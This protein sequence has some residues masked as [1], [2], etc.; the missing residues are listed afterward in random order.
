M[1]LVFDFVYFLLV[2][3]TSVVSTSAIIC[4]ERLISEVICYVLNGTL[5][6]THSLAESL[7]V[8]RCAKQ[9]ICYI[10]GGVF[11]VFVGLL[12]LMQHSLYSRQTSI[13]QHS[14]SS[15][16][17]HQQY[18]THTRPA[19]GGGTST[20]DVSASDDVSDDDVAVDEGQGQSQVQGE[21]DGN[22]TATNSRTRDINHQ[23]TS[24]FTRRLHVDG[25]FTS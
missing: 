20:A 25:R 1:S 18:T 24:S 7:L 22:E 23:Q 11:C 13:D 6:P 5:N 21:S 12:S 16:Q 14:H 15:S 4:L 17:N 19:A 3:V 2:N 8:V 10:H 9:N